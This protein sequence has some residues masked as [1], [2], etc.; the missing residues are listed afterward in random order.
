MIVGYVRGLGIALL[1]QRLGGA[2]LKTFG[3]RLSAS[4]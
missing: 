4:P 2:V 3:G 1:V